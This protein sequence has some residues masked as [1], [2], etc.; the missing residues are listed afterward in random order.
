MIR[1]NS[2]HPSMRAKAGRFAPILLTGVVALTLAVAGP[3][4]SPVHAQSTDLPIAEDLINNVQPS[5][6]ML[7]EAEELHYDLDNDRISAVGNVQI[8]FN[9]FVLEAERVTLDRKTSRLIAEGNVRLIEPD[10]NIVTAELI[11][12]SDDF[13]DGF[14]ESLRVETVERTRFAAERAERVDENTTIFHRGVYTACSTCAQTPEKPPTWQIKAA[15][16]VHNRQEK[17]IY[18]TDAKLEFWG[19]PVMYLP[20]LSAPDPTVRRKSGLLAPRTV[21]SEK[22]GF[23]VSVPYFW[24]LA[25]NMDVTLTATPLTKQGVL[26]AGE[27]R[28]RLSNGLYSVRAVGL[29]QQNPEEFNGTSGDRRY[30]GMLRT[31]GRFS[32]NNNWDWGWDLTLLSDRSFSKDYYQETTTP[33][34]AISTIYLT[35]QSLRNYFDARFY[36]FTVLQEDPVG[37]PDLVDP[38][39]PPVNL[40][41]QQ[42]FVHPSVDYNYVFSDPVFSGELSF[43]MSFYGMTRETTD[44]LTIAGNTQYFGVDGVHSRFALDLKWRKS[45]INKLG[46]VLTPFASLRGDVFAIGNPPNGLR[47]PGGVPAGIPGFTNDDVVFRGMPM[48]GFEA[49]WPFVSSHQWGAQIFEPVA[50][51][52]ARPSE[53]HIGELPNEDA[54]SLVFDD[55]TLFD[56][57][58]F[59]GFDRAEGGTRA[60]VGLQ[61]KALF[62]DG[63]YISALFGQS[64]HLA[65]TNSFARQGLVRL[66]QDS[67][68]EDNHSDYVGRLYLDTNRGLRFGARMR[69]DQHDF[70]VNR[71]EVGATGIAGPFVGTINYSFLRRQPSLGITDNREEILGAASLRVR[72]NWRLFGSLRYDLQN[73][74]FV[75]DAIGLAFDDESLSLSLS[76]AEDRSRNNRDPV[77]RVVFFRLGLRTLGDT[78]TSTTLDD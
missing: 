10:G 22:L 51:I 13:R 8:Y 25:P 16:I 76:Y 3:T 52:I 23:G 36:H 78:S 24:V 47:T 62:R 5:D 61:Y 67:G 33:D 20:F 32:I 38:I 6:R 77:D 21:F 35:G 74:A 29:H 60:N 70:R 1:V 44:A 56:P 28:H 41:E 12:L 69:I 55:T 7:V 45:L 54:Q 37:H 34:E 72:R 63:G 17:M 64:Y 65:G 43:D 59:S 46:Q 49:R 4:L 31:I 42:P 9:G 14:V 68:L 53:T 2:V 66:P 71:S 18:F 11:N 50:Q 75:R 73:S 40:Q 30:R 15:K 26:M 58:K 19:V 57:D 48:A 27:F 39:S